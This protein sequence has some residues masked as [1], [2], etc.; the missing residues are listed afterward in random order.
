MPKATIRPLHWIAKLVGVVLVEQ[1]LTR[2]LSKC[3]ETF[4]QMEE[5]HARNGVH[6]LAIFHA[7]EVRDSTD[8]H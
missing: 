2:H 8:T 4:R 1:V 5:S 3:E 7:T 6:R